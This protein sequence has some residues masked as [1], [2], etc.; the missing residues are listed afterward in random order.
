MKPTLIFLLLSCQVK[1]T[2]PTTVYLCD[3]QKAKK[4]HLT[5]SCRGLRNCQHRIIKINLDKAKSSGK[6]LCGWEK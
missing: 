5:E 2:A 6:T 1:P 3:S 4:Y